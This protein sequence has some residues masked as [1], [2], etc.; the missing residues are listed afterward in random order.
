MSALP[1]SEILDQDKK[2]VLAMLEIEKSLRD[3][4]VLTC[5]MSA[6]GYAATRL[7][8]YAIKT[9]AGADKD[10][11]AEMFKEAW[12]MADVGGWEVVKEQ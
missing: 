9:G 3:F 5:G 2:C 1:E 10:K 7:K 11:W 4:D 12:D 8:L 6:L